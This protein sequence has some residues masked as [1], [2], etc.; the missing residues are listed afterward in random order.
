MKTA[1][2]DMIRPLPGLADAIEARD[3][4]QV[5][6]VLAENREHIFHYTPFAGATW[7]HFA[8]SEG[9][10]SIVEFLIDQGLDVNVGDHRDGRSPLADA[11]FGGHLDVVRLLLNRGAI[12][13]TSS[14]VRN[15][16]FAAISGS[17][18]I[19]ASWAPPTGEAP[20]IVSLLLEQGIDSR[21]RYN[22]PTMKNMDAISFA[23]QMG[24][25]ELGRMVALWNANGDEDAANEA[26][27][28][29]RIIAGIDVGAGPN[30]SAHS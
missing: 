20:G 10:T 27:R 26:L 12:L 23:I 19:N 7:L 8:A 24:A 14:S 1:M 30:R 17:I 2:K 25:S 29:A 28:E 18:H 13:D 16:L 9:A 3:L 21:V 15:P 11:A 22:S 5:K 4:D 6:I